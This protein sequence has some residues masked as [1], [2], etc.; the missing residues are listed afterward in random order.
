MH[1]SEAVTGYVAWRL[2]AGFRNPSAE[3]IKQTFGRFNPSWG[4]D[5]EDFIIDE[6]AAAISSMLAQRHRIAHGEW[7]DITYTRVRE[8]YGYIQ[9]VVDRLADLVI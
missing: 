7:S 4:N 3:N 5:L 2:T 9:D 1:A 6:H 8:H